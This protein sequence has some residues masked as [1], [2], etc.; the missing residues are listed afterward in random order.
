MRFNPFTFTG[1]EKDQETGY[2]YFGARYMDHELMTM[3]LSVDPMSD[4]YPSISPYAYCAWNPIKLVDPDGRE[5]WKPEAY[6][7]GDVS[8]KSEVGDKALTLQKQYGRSANV[9]QQLYGTMKNG[10]I[11]GKSVAK[12]NSGNQILKVDWSNATDHQK[13]Y[14]AFFAIL[15]EETTGRGTQADLNNYF[16]NLPSHKLTKE[17]LWE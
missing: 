6:S 17:C 9:A 3:W 5:M 4:K 10:R 15:H 1:K 14:Q 7:T 8:Y 12:F 13:I 2:G 11:S 16:K